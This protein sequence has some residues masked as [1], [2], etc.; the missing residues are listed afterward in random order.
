MEISAMYKRNQV[1]FTL[2]ELM[3]VVAI[4][5]IISAIALPSYQKN[6]ERT[7]RSDAQSALMGLAAAMER[8]YTINGTYEGNTVGDNDDKGTP[9]PAFFPSEAPIDSG[10]KFYDL[11]ISY[12]TNPQSYTVYALPKGVQA[13]DG[14]MLLTSTGQRGWAKE[15]ANGVADAQYTDDW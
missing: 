3:I 13:N 8:A 5:G 11:R 10:A 4:I 14:P 1:G 12:T 9:L 15:K 2:I 6:V 7:R